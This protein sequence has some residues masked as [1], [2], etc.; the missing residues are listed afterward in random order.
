MERRVAAI[1]KERTEDD[2]NN[3][4]R[5]EKHARCALLPSPESLDT[6]SGGSDITGTLDDFQ[7]VFKWATKCKL[8]NTEFL[9]RGDSERHLSDASFK[10]MI[11]NA[12]GVVFDAVKNTGDP[13]LNELMFWYYAGHGLDQQNAQQLRYCASPVLERVKFSKDRFQEARHFLSDEPRKVK[14]GELCLHDIGFCDINGL[15]KPF[16]DC[17]K[18]QSINSSEEKKENKHLLMV[19]DSCFSGQFADDLTNWFQEGRNYLNEG[20]TVTVQASCGMNEMAVGGYF[21]PTFIY[22]NDPK[23][24]E[25]LSTLKEEW[26]KMNEGDKAKIRNLPFASPVV[27]TTRTDVDNSQPTLEFEVQNFQMTLFRDAGFFK[28][29]YCE[30][31]NCREMNELKGDRRL[32]PQ[33]AKTFLSQKQFNVIDFKL[34]TMNTGKFAGH[35]LGLFLI[36]DPMHANLAICAHVHFAAGDTS[37]VGRIN[38][39]HHIRSPHLL[40]FESEDTAGLLGNQKRKGRHKIPLAMVPNRPNPDDKDPAHWVF[41][42]WKTGQYQSFTALVAAELNAGNSVTTDK[43]S[44][45]ECAMEL[46]TKCHDFVEGQPSCKGWWDDVTK[47]H[48]QSA[49]PS[50]HNKFRRDEGRFSSM[51][52]YLEKIKEYDLPK[53]PTVVGKP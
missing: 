50:Y 11:A 9:Q 10:S 27:Q 36:K 45:V 42:R 17:I 34:K 43:K 24:K 46:V 35:P 51:T 18:H 37:K 23:N 4:R 2:E 30:V 39:V 26:N 49:D 22:L 38:L 41:W 29:C 19:L 52:N 20:C 44:E 32:S 53:V 1:T 33:T 12:F 21:T 13:T 7:T 28:Y 14:G 8:L 25:F 3:L 15:L 5:M 40:E 48:S 6:Y 16:I 31:F 47:W